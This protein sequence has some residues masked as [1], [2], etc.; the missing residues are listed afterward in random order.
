MLGVTPAQFALGIAPSPASQYN[1]QV[2]GN[3]KLEP[4]VGKT[5]NVGIVF[6]PSFLPRFSATVDFTDIKISNLVQSY[7][8]NLIQANC[9]AS[10]SIASTWCQAIHRNTVGSLWSSPQGYTIDPLINEGALEAKGIDVK[11]L[12][13]IRPSMEDVFVAMIETEERRAA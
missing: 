12:E 9:I 7:G 3:P 1:G 11:G 8:P 2:G 6:T 4:E 5:I 13:Q 10:G